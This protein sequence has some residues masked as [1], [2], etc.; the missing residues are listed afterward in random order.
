MQLTEG[1]ARDM[2][3]AEDVR[4]RINCRRLFRESL[5]VR[6]GTRYLAELSAR[7]G[8]HPGLVAAAYNAG[9]GNVDGWLEAAGDVPF[10][11]WLENLP[12]QQPRQYVK[13]VLAAW[14]VYR[15]LSTPPEAPLGDRVP[16]VPLAPVTR[17]A[18]GEV[19]DPTLTTQAPP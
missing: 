12:Y 3:A 5:N 17:I 8:G 9:P 11:T 18:Q 10:D 14:F 16:I 1:T 4:L 13:R 15:W 2:A 7:L 19:P 6:L